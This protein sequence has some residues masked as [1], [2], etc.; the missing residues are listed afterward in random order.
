MTAL[1]EQ[2]GQ[3]P[4]AGDPVIHNVRVDMWLCGGCYDAIFITK[5]QR[6][7]SPVSASASDTSVPKAKAEAEAKTANSNVGREVAC[8]ETSVGGQGHESEP[9]ADAQL[10][11]LLRAHREGG[12]MPEPVEG[13]GPLPPNPSRAERAAYEL[14]RLCFGLRLADGTSEPL[15]MAGSVLVREGIVRSDRGGRML[16][17]R[18]ERLGVIWSP[19]ALAP[20]HQRN[21]PHGTK[22]WLP[23]RRPSGPE[24]EGGWRVV[25]AS[26][27]MPGAVFERGAVAVEAERVVRGVAVEPA[28]EPPEKAEVRGAEPADALGVVVAER[29]GAGAVG[30]ES[31]HPAS[32][33]A[34]TGGTGQPRS[35]IYGWD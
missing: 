7:R 32:I 16:L 3:A 31:S 11:E 8:G 20:M 29:D 14:I 17:C 19:G 12:F 35:A 4:S 30:V 10:W 21:R 25:P 15:P 28:G 2:C 27:G 24:P 26:D 5:T 33:T 9:D 13:L 6:P 23:G 1:C 22:L 18:F 34:R